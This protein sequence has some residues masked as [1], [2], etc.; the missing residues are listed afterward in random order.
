MEC[1]NQYLPEL[2]LICLFVVKILSVVKFLLAINC[3]WHLDA[4]DLLMLAVWIGLMNLLQTQ[5]RMIHRDKYM[6]GKH[7]VGMHSALCFLVS[8]EL[9]DGG[10][11][12]L[13]WSESFFVLIAGGCLFCSFLCLLSSCQVFFFFFWFGVPFSLEICP[14]PSHSYEVQLNLGTNLGVKYDFIFWIALFNT[15]LE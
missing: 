9:A 4:E 14:S 2:C 6:E 11:Y 3:H 7:V 15:L 13:N 5:R 8:C 1:W 12:H 10:C